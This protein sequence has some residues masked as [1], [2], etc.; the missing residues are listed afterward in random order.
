[1]NRQLMFCVLT[2]AAV[3]AAPS[4]K[5]ALLAVDIN[6]RTVGDPGPA[7]PANTAPGFLPY[8]ISS[9]TSSTGVVGGYTL[10]FDVFDDGDAND[11]GAAGNQ[12]GAFDDRDR[13]VPT[14]AP[15]LNEIYDDFLF[16]GGSAGPVGGIDMRI[17]GGA[18]L[19]NTPYLVSVYAYDGI[20]ANF[21]SATQTRTANWFDGNN[22]DAMVFTTQFTVNM[23]PTTDDQYKF[24]GV[25]ITDGAGQLFLKGRRVT[26]ADLAV[27]VNG[28]VVDAIPEPAT[29]VLAGVGGLALWA[30]AGRGRPK[31]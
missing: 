8:V 16:V 27:Y 1:M 6:D 21:G 10:N 31:T 3:W 11:G 5:A 2:A 12:P 23:P 9:G 29:L 25:A 14:G 19:P 7:D 24:T 28:V 20:D 13:V 22:G 15:T 4:A 26:A 18:L 30:A 17:S